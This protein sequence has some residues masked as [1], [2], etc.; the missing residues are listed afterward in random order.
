MRV[1]VNQFFVDS[2]QNVSHIKCSFFGTDFG[3][4][5]DVQHQVAKFLFNAIQI[6]LQNGIGQFIGFLN[7]EFSQRFQCLFP[8]PRAF[9]TEL[10]HDIK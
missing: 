1:T 9:I 8:V 7:G 10:V 4:K 5:N 2:F 3:I 6:V